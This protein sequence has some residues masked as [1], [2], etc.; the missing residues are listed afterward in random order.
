M[1]LGAFAVCSLLMYNGVDTAIGLRSS[2]VDFSCSFGLKH[3]CPMHR[4]PLVDVL[5][6]ALVR[7]ML[8]LQ[9][10]PWQASS[11]SLTSVLRWLNAI[12]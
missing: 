6:D 9:A 8:T 11:E 5:V 3:E 4:I 2:H 10:G 7:R 12:R 1:L